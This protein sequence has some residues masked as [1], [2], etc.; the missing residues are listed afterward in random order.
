MFCALLTSRYQVSVY[1]T[2]GPLVIGSDKIHNLSGIVKKV[3]RVSKQ[4]IL[5]YL[6]TCNKDANGQY[7]LSLFVH[8]GYKTCFCMMG[9]RRKITSSRKGSLKIFSTFIL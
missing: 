3:A 2:N 6:S 4:D 7:V 1:R 8:I 5:Y 9:P